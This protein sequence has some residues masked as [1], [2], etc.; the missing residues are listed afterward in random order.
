M[1][2]EDFAQFRIFPHKNANFGDYKRR[3][4]IRLLKSGKG[5]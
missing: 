4:L 5:V 1:L 2:Y 3:L